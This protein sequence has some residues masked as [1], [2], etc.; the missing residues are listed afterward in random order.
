MLNQ[1][2]A[3]MRTE[4]TQVRDVVVSQVYRTTNYERFSFIQGNRQLNKMH[5]ERLKKSIAETDLTETNPILV[6]EN[7]EIIDGQ[8]RYEVCKELKKPIHYILK[9]GYGLREVQMLNANMK[10]WRLEDY[11]DGYCDMGKEEYL[12]L[13]SFIKEH[14]L[15]MTNS[16]Q[17]LS[18]MGGDKAQNIM[19]GKMTLPNKGRGSVVAGWVKQL[20]PMYGGVKRRSFIN[21][22]SKF[23][24]NRQFDFKQLVAKLQYQQTKLV[25]CTDTK[26]YL[27]LLEEIYNFKERG[28]KLRFF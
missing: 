25:D 11:V 19:D 22:L 27:T 23:Y 17:L 6:N 18:N 4:G 9:V 21:A 3:P 20:E 26:G 10:N 12:F 24:S 15:G 2:D 1:E 13:R 14:K 16:V 7:F 28:E 5:Q 8:H